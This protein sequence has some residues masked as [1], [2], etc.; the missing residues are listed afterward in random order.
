MIETLSKNT[1]KKFNGKKPNKRNEKEMNDGMWPTKNIRGTMLNSCVARP[2]SGATR[3]GARIIRKESFVTT[4][5]D[6]LL[7]V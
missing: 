3:K 7:Q 2:N 1:R 5:P 4:D 6:A